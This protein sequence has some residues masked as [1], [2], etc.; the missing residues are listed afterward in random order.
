MASRNGVRGNETKRLPRAARARLLASNNF[1]DP[2]DERQIL[3]MAGGIF[4]PPEQ[5]IAGE[6][7]LEATSIV[8]K[9]AERL[10]GDGVLPGQG[11]EAR[12]SDGHSGGHGQMVRRR[13][14]ARTNHE[15]RIWESSPRRSG[16]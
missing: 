11:T 2:E 8:A 10:F 12:G 4:G 9:E 13:G 5:A 15:A 7:D 14:V 3:N 6:V 1:L 16:W